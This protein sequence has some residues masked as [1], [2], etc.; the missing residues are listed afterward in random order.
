MS[1]HRGTALRPT[2][3]IARRIQRVAIALSTLLAAGIA[4]AS[5]RSIEDTSPPERFAGALK[6]AVVRS[7]AAAIDSANPAE[8]RLI[9]H[10]HSG[11]AFEGDVPDATIAQQVTVL[12]EAFRASGLHF[13]LAE[14]RR[15]RDSEFFAGACYPTTASGIRMKA[16]LAVDPA[17]FVNIYLCKIPEGLAG[18]ATFPNEF[19]QDDHQHGII[20]DYRTLPGGPAPLNLGHTLVHEMGHYLGLL[21]TFQGGCEPP[22]DDVD[23]TPAEAA[24]AYGCAIGRDTCAAPGVDPVTNFMNYSDDACTD[25]FTPLQATRMHALIAT[26]RPQLVSST[27]AIGAGMTGNWYSPAQ[28]GHGFEIQV[29]PGNQLLVEWFVFTP[30]GQPTWIIGT[31]PISGDTA[32]VQGFQ[33]VGPGGRFPPRFN[34]AQVHPQP[35]GTLEF[36]FSGCDA[37]EV[38]WTAVA[39]GYGNGSLPLVRLTMPL[40]LTCP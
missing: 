13:T 32:I 30:D 16:E 37:G 22:G 20:I 6:Q 39:P 15:Y 33:Q 18:R 28:S 17:K 11:A 38:R 29:L 2:L 12:N 34:S 5:P 3:R 1:E 8:I 7:K 9:V 26:F 27:F 21:H 31:G 35:W 40:G 23:D 25:Q 14:T 36:Q 10:V 4:V 24:P 19:P